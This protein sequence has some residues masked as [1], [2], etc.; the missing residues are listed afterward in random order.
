MNPGRSTDL[1]EDFSFG[2][3]V[4]DGTDYDSDVLIYPDGRVKDSWWR[5]EGHK[6][7]FGDIEPLL[8]TRPDILVA[9]TGMSG[10]MQPEPELMDYLKKQ[11][12]QL[13]ALPNSDAVEQYNHSPEGKDIAGCFH[14]TC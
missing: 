5:K 3:I 8:E 6:L 9:G 10:M 12:I 1:I 14:L 13:I 7:S 11:G 4:I 2:H